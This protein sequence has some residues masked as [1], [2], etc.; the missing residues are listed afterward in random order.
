MDEN[1]ILA[2]SLSLQIYKTVFADVCYVAAITFAIHHNNLCP[3]H[4]S[5]DLLTFSHVGGRGTPYN[6]W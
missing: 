3:Q 2:S 6:V 5:R 4:A 1:F